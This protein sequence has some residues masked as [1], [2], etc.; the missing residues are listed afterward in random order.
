M[1]RLPSAFNNDYTSSLVLWLLATADVAKTGTWSDRSGNSNDCVLYH[2]AEVTQGVGLALDGTDDYGEVSQSAELEFGAAGDFS[3][4]YWSK[5]ADNDT[6][7]AA[8]A[9]GD[10]VSTNGITVY[11]ES[12]DAAGSEPEAYIKGAGGATNN[13]AT[14]AVDDNAWHH[15]VLAVDRSGDMTFHVDGGAAEGAHDISGIGDMDAG[16]ARDWQIGC[17][18]DTAARIW[19]FTGTLDDIRIYSEPLA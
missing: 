17:V 8:M 7:M 4:A 5:F 1:I 3:L 2:D 10:R 9:Y 18:I 19:H 16:S 14:T 6:Y 13:A 15:V 11:G 12:D